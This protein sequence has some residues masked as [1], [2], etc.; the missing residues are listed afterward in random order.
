MNNRT[1]SSSGSGSGR[2]NNN[3]Q[4][5]TQQQQQ[6]QQQQRNS[7]KYLCVL[8]FEATCDEDRSFG[9]QEIIEF[10]S[11]LCQF[12]RQND[13]VTCEIV[14]EFQQ[15]IK[16]IHNPKLTQFCTSL[17][18][19]TQQQVDNGISFSD[20]L[21]EH[22]KWLESHLNEPVTDKNVLIVTCG[23][24]DL[25]TALPN[26]MRLESHSSIPSYLRQWC[27]IKFAYSQF[28]NKRV[29]GMVQMLRDLN[30]KLVG[31]HHSGIDDCR[32]IAQVVIAAHKKKCPFAPTARA[33]SG[34]YKNNVPY[35]VNATPA[36][37]FTI[38]DKS[39]ASQ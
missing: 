30:L 5:H 9:P 7:F 37:S 32:N 20:A 3:R 26:Q 16:P 23:D 38:C 31:R 36:S 2:F 10:P 28:F 25:K 17:T 11:V 33:G 39:I 29:G 24:W 34:G 27:N 35:D 19:I 14:D 4:H 22:R 15:Y 12:I 21:S 13:I 18:G 1:N 6:Q 8:D